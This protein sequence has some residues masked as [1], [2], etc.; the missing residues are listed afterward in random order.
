MAPDWDGR[1]GNAAKALGQRFFSAQ[2]NPIRLGSSG[3][4]D[5]PRTFK[6]YELKEG[7]PTFHY[8]VGA[9]DVFE[10]VTAA[11]GGGVTRT[12][13]I[14]PGGAR[15]VFFV[16]PADEPAAVVTSP[17]GEFKPGQTIKSYKPPLE[18]IPAKVL[19]LPASGKLTFAVTVRPKKRK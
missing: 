8:T 9:A 18:Q 6:G 15:S 19:E 2:T 4:A 10:R 7:V 12:F 16:T 14:E 11:E 17:A 13:E 3:D 1:G 5:V